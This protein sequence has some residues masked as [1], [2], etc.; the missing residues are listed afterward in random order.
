M[1]FLAHESWVLLWGES[2]V[3]WVKKKKKDATDESVE[4][5]STNAE[6]GE[7]LHSKL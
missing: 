3:L 2:K 5:T 1:V 7:C 6:D 4:H